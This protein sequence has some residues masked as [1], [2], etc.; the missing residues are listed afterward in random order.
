MVISL[1][2]S[3]QFCSEIASAVVVEEVNVISGDE[4]DEEEEE[5]EEDKNEDD[6]DNDEEVDTCFMGDI[7]LIEVEEVTV[8]GIGDVEEFVE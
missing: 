3:V 7:H 5:D 4:E 2:R 6:D 1:Q 8:T